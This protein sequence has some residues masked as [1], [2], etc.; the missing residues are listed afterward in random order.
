MNLDQLAA[1]GMRFTDAHSKRVP[2]KRQICN[3]FN[4]L[5]LRMLWLKI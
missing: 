2:D 3:G 1:E 5:I 4:Y